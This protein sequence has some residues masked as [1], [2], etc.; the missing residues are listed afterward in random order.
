MKPLP[1]GFAPHT[2]TSPA[3]QAWQPIYAQVTE[4]AFRLGLWISEAHCNS[5]GHLHG[6]VIATLADNA[7]GLTYGM[8]LAS[9]E[10]VITL[11]L[12]VDYLTSA[13]LGSWFEIQP[14]LIRAGSTIGVVDADILGDGDR[15]ARASAIYR[16]V[17][18]K[19]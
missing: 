2:R 3:I 7:M 1:D 11:K 6:G 14:R 10:G 13:K 12:D 15:I 4:D 17:Q 16:C 5:R 8:G 19:R 9:P 18:P